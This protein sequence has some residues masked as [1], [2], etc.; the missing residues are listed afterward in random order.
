[1]TSIQASQKQTVAASDRRYRIGRRTW[2]VL[3]Y[4]LL[5]FFSLFV[6]IPFLF[7]ITTSLKTESQLFVWPIEWIPDPVAWQNYIQ[8]FVELGRI[9]PGLTFWRIL[10]NTLFITLLAMTAELAAVSLVAYGFAR[11]RFPGR[12]VLFIIMLATM[13][14]PSI[15][16]LIP[17]FLI[18]RNLNLIDT[19]D[20]LVSRIWLGGGAW[21]VFMLRQFLL[22]IPKDMEEAAVI[23]G[24]NAFQIYYMIM[25]PL[26]RPAMLALAVLIFQGNWNNFMGP[27]IY[28]NTTVKFPMIVALKFFQESLS[29]EAPKWHYMM[30][31]SGVM[32]AP[33]LLLFFLAQR[34][35]IEGLQVGGVKG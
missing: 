32:A 31:M 35:F 28:L 23:D 11:F 10:S 5:I 14:L 12:N 7:M 8:A 9:A 21:A 17:T 2:R 4:G 33:L 15:I 24:A 16:T 25:L 13:M 3:V 27:L 29:K 34:Y 6:F 1:M 26:I 30:A 20:P 19:Y 18:W 22:T